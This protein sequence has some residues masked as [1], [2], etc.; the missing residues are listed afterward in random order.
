MSSISWTS[1][2][3]SERG[4]RDGLHVAV[5]YNPAGVEVD[6]TPGWGT[7]VD[8]GNLAIHVTHLAEGQ[9]D[10]ALCH[11]APRSHGQTPAIV[12]QAPVT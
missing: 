8:I 11:Q 2:W 10:C 9:G 12:S 5:H 7:D 6:V 4:W 3:R 1:G